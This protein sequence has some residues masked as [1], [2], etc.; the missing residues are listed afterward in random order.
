MEPDD[1]IIVLLLI[2]LCPALSCVPATVRRGKP[3]KRFG[4]A[5]IKTSAPL[6]AANWNRDELVLTSI[7]I[8]L[9][10]DD[11]VEMVGSPVDIVRML[12]EA[13]G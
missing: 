7:A 9:I 13:T 10:N 8:G 6:P 12:A 4:R 2:E 1:A 5:L 11:T 3:I